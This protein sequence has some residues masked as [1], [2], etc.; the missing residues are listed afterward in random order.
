V[1]VPTARV[2]ALLGAAI[3]AG[4]LVATYWPSHQ[5]SAAPQLAGASA[6][7]T[8]QLGLPHPSP[9]ADQLVDVTVARRDHAPV[10]LDQVTLDA[11][12][13]SMG[14][15][16]PA[17]TAVQTAPG[18]YRTQGQLFLMAGSW[19]LTVSL[20]GANG[21]ETVAIWVPVAAN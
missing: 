4:V 3:V 14:H 17:L 20:H 5:A 15:T 13:P 2:Q 8:V 10:G 6:D 18:H 1:T 12:M 7:Y 21:T 19:Q 9:R 11:L 16:M